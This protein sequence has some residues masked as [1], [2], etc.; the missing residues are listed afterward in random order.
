MGLGNTHNPPILVGL[1]DISK[2]LGLGLYETQ[3]LVRA[4]DIPV[5]KI[6]RSWAAPVSWLAEW[7]GSRRPV[8]MGARRAG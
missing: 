5:M 7:I 6:G 2:A 8:P 4:G 3:A 1:K